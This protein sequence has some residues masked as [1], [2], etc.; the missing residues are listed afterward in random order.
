MC[1][2]Q[3]TPAETLGHQGAA[4]NALDCTL[5]YSPSAKTLA[6][7]CRTT[8]RGCESGRACDGPV[9]PFSRATYM[10]MSKVHWGGFE[11]KHVVMAGAAFGWRAP[12]S[13]LQ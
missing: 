8:G 7:L 9:D 1:D 12:W 10:N 2:G 13:G 5:D 3:L 4:F 6:V 11:T